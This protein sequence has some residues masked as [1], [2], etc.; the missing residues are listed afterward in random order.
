MVSYSLSYCTASGC[1][2]T[3]DSLCRVLEGDAGRW[4]GQWRCYQ[5]SLLYCAQH[6]VP[7][8]SLKGVVVSHHWTLYV[9]R[10][11]LTDRYSILASGSSNCQTCVRVVSLL[12]SAIGRVLT[13]PIFGF[14]T[15]ICC[16]KAAHN[17][18]M[19][20]LVNMRTERL[21]DQLGQSQLEQRLGG[22]FQAN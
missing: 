1:Q 19:S 16:L 17:R 5:M 7:T 2:R 11:A 20:L 10:A 6:I 9:N 18:V 8:P 22:L 14:W 3:A 4:V 21:F 15:C 13:L 12:A